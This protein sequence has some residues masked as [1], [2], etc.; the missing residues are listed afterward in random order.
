MELNDLKLTD[1]DVIVLALFA[2]VIVL[3]LVAILRT[4]SFK[5][6]MREMQRNQELVAKHINDVRRGGDVR[7]GNDDPTK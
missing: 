2:C 4:G 6:Q 7:W 5:G 3:Q 1:F